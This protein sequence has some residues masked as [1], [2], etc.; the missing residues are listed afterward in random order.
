M[1]ANRGLQ[2]HGRDACLRVQGVYSTERVKSRITNK[3]L[4]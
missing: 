2:L 3:A 1:F 4:D